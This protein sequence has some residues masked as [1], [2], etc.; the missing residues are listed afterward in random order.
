M[1]THHVG[2]ASLRL[3]RIKGNTNSV[4]LH[5]HCTARRDVGPQLWNG[6]FRSSTFSQVRA[7][8]GRGGTL[9]ARCYSTRDLLADVRND[10]QIVLLLFCSTSLP[11]DSSAFP[12]AAPA[13][14]ISDL[15]G[16]LQGF[17][18][19]ASPARGSG[20][21]NCVLLPIMR[22]PSRSGG[23]PKHILQNHR[24]AAMSGCG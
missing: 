19:I 2:L 23:M 9:R 1:A 15:S 11:P 20:R 4:D 7:A 24:D 14:I 18:S 16:K 3:Q 21:S 8:F 12:T 6:S 5:R 13:V 22:K 10:G 17:Y